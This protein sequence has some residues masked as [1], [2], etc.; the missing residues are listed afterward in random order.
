MADRI[1]VLDRMEW[2]SALRLVE[3]AEIRPI[4]G[5]YDN[6]VQVPEG[7]RDKNKVGSQYS[8]ATF[9]TQAAGSA[10]AGDIPEASDLLKACGLTELINV[11]TDVQYSPNPT[12]GS[13]PVDLDLFKGN[14]LKYSCDNAVG[15]YAVEFLPGEPAHEQWDFFG[16]Y[17]AVTDA[18]GAASRGTTASPPVCKGLVASFGGITATLKRMSMGLGMVTTSPDLDIAG[19]NGIQNPQH[20]DRDIVFEATFREPLVASADFY[21]MMIGETKISI[22]VVLGSVAGNIITYAMDGYIAEPIDPG[23]S[24]G[25]HELTVKCRMSWIAAD[26]QLTV[27]YT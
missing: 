19:T 15:N 24:Q 17:A 22:S 4:A 2:G 21:A 5:F 20:S 18:S 8:E 26:T 3:D 23:S 25:M 13:T 12:F 16:T 14:A 10:T 1:V 27:I 9:K 6:T 11:G 7:S